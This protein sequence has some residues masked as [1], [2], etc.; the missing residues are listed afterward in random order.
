MFLSCIFM[1]LEDICIY[2][3]LNKLVKLKGNPNDLEDNKKN[4]SN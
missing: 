3:S 4:D 1:F 2:K